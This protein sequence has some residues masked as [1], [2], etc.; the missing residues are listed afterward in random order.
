MIYLFVCCILLLVG[1]FVLGAIHKAQSISDLGEQLTT[2][3]GNNL[4]A[5]LDPMAWNRDDE[6]M[7]IAMGK[8]RG[9]L[10]VFRRVGLFKILA[11]CA[12]KANPDCEAD[13]IIIIRQAWQFRIYAVLCL[14]E[15]A[16]CRCI[17]WCRRTPFS[18]PMARQCANL[19]YDMSV[20]LE[21]ALS[22]RDEEFTLI[23]DTTVF[24]S[25]IVDK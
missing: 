19:Y 6:G 23:T 9:L 3:E 21:I 13:A 20:R 5:H 25:T 10:K 24:D 7:W 11:A 15:A 18:R 22:M 14:A 4:F 17:P 8:A 12:R 1:W 16:V 2:H